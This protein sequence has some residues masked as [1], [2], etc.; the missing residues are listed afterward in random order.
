MQ[1]INDFQFLLTTSTKRSGN[2]DKIA[3]THLHSTSAEK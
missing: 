2:V 3:I 1:G